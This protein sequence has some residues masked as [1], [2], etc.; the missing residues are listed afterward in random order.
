MH[1]LL[2]DVPAVFLPPALAIWIA[3]RPFGR[4]MILQQGEKP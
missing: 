4:G 2:V 1:A 3:W